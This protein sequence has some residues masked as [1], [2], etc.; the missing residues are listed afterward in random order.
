MSSQIHRPPT[1]RFQSELDLTEL[2]ATLADISKNIRRV[3]YLRLAAKALDQAVAEMKAAK[4]QSWGTLPDPAE[5]EK[6]KRTIP[7]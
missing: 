2:A 7:N 4:R 3:P 5:H 6:A 1:N